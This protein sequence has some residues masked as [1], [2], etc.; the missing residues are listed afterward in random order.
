MAD[1]DASGYDP[2]CESRRL[3][4]WQLTRFANM[5]Q[6]Q[7]IERAIDKAGTGRALAHSLGRWCHRR[8]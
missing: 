2:D 1:M 7:L 8:T 5:R 6:E 3:R 4:A